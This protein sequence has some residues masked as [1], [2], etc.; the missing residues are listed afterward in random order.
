M[1]TLTKEIKKLIEKYAIMTETN[2]LYQSIMNL[3]EGQPN[4]QAWAIRMV[5]SNILNYDQLTEIAQWAHSNGQLIS[6]LKKKNIVAYNKRDVTSLLQEMQTLTKEKVIKD[7]ISYFNTEQRRLLT[8]WYQSSC[9]TTFTLDS[10]Y[11][12]F[13][14]FM[15]MPMARK[16][17]FYSTCSAVRSTS[18]LLSLIQ[19]CLSE[20]YDW[21]LGKEDLIRY[22]NN[23]TKDCDIT[24]NNDN[25]VVVE[26]PSFE[27]SHRLCGSGRTQWCISRE[28]GYWRSYVT[29]YDNK[30]RQFF[31]FDFNRK[32]TDAFAHIGF[33]VQKGRGIVEAQTCNNFS[34]MNNYTQGNETYNIY[35][36]MEKNK[37][38]VDAFMRLPKNLGYEWK[39]SVFTKIVKNN[40]TSASILYHQDGFMVIAFK[41]NSLLSSIFEKGFIG[42]DNFAPNSS[43]RIVA[44]LNF[45]LKQD[46]AHA[47]T[48][49][50]LEKDAYEQED[51]KYAENLYGQKLDVNHIEEIIQLPIDKFVSNKELDPNILLHKYIDTN[52]EDKAIQ[53]L[54]SDAGK[55]IDVNFEYNSKL[56]IYMAINQRMA[57][58]FDVIVNHPT[59][60]PAISDGLGE[61]LVDSIIYLI[62][63][64]KM[65]QISHDDLNLLA[66]MLTSIM[67]VPHYNFNIRKLNNETTLH[68]VCEFPQLSKVAVNLISRKYIDVNAVNDSNDTALSI[69][70]KNKN[71]D[72][73]S[74]LCKRPDLVI[75]DM[76]KKAAKANNIDLQSY[77]NPIED[78][79]TDEA[80]STFVM[81]QIPSID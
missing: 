59:F 79:A 18:T 36:F 49:I 34:M 39:A 20:S 72:A 19:D 15:H 44:V 77:I 54:C 45:N 8:E 17:K 16:Q 6:S 41:G 60:N 48:I 62:A 22:I 61:T 70:L 50:K 55:N 46:D 67:N 35:S 7:V 53:L 69:S 76:D 5:F 75:T 21:Q 1:V 4:Y 29:D 31:I 33:T 51:V 47:V 26:V 32:E 65:L 30:R 14:K 66:Y 24:Y 2:T 80:T 25:I 64:A 37:I 12:M 78:F 9:G 57:K 74:A 73:V 68:T 43:C 52:K 71:M 27:S 38:P 42:F 11:D 13:N 10:I 56:P 81:E 23:V 63:S 40:S 28:V 3:F 58:L